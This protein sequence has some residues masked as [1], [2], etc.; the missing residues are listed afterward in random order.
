MIPK[1]ETKTMFLTFTFRIPKGLMGLNVLSLHLAQL[2]LTVNA[3]IF[4]GGKGNLLILY[5]C[6]WNELM[7]GT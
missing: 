1:R 4:S 6:L 3:A 7:G 5:P 2:G